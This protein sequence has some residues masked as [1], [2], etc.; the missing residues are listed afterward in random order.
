M[1]VNCCWC[2]SVIQNVIERPPL[3][4]YLLAVDNSDNT[5]EEIVK[6]CLAV[7]LTAPSN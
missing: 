6:V 1:Y 5:L 3:P 7:D 4:G 2:S